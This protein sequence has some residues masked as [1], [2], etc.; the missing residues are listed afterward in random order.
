MFLANI[1]ITFFFCKAFT[2]VDST[3]HNDSDDQ[4]NNGICDAKE[5]GAKAVTDEDG[6]KEQNKDSGEDGTKAV[7]VEDRAKDQN[8]DAV[9]HTEE[10]S[11]DGDA[12]KVHP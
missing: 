12:K 5:D 4:E 10:N 6:A 3:E 11:H 9:V 2:I 7:A 8:E 1:T